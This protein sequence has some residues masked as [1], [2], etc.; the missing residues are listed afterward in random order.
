MLIR[1][2]GSGA[3]RDVKVPVRIGLTVT[4]HRCTKRGGVTVDVSDVRG[5]G[6][7]GIDRENPRG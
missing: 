4:K 5:G 2:R 7:G 6:R 3:T 1:P